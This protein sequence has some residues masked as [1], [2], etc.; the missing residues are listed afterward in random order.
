MIDTIRFKIPVEK[1]DYERIIKVCNQRTETDNQ[2]GNSGVAFYSKNIKLG[3]YNYCQNIFVYD[4]KCIYVEF[5]AP[6]IVYGHNIFLLYPLQLESAVVKAKE[7]IEK[8]L[9]V[10]LIDHHNWIIQRLDLCYSWK[11]RSDLDAYSV[12]RTLDSYDYSRK[13]KAVRDTSIEYIGSAYKIKFYLKKDEYLVHDLK[14]LEQLDD[15]HASELINTAKGVL[16]YEVSLK[17]EVLTYPS[18][19]NLHIDDITDEFC[20]ENL[21]KYLTKLIGNNNRKTIDYVT[22]SRLLFRKYSKQ[23]A[24]NLLE[25][26]NLYFCPDKKQREI[27]RKYILKQSNRSTIYR[28]KKALRDVGIGIKKLEKKGIDFELCIPSEDVINNETIGILE[29]M[30]SIFLD[31][32]ERFTIRDHLG[33]QWLGSSKGLSNAALDDQPPKRLLVEG[34]TQ[35]GSPS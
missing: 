3:S 11:F 25:F 4:P 16:R 30:K 1:Q 24:S 13:Q 8:E 27:N 31:G 6:K 14:R 33:N 15:I 34:E 19:Y 23:K 26:Y 29:M 5:S 18:N 28:K 20:I 32:N 2:T 22:V 9:E 10:K 35:S 12:L 21:N 17:K 7:K